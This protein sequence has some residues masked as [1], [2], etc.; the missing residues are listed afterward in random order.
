MINNHDSPKLDEI[1][2]GYV[3][4]NLDETELAWLNQELATNPQLRERIKQLEAT[5]TLIPY[6]LTDN[7]PHPL[8]KDKILSQ[9][10]LKQA[11]PVKFNRLLGITSV[12]TILSTLWLGLNNYGLR[13]QIAIQNNQLQ[14]HQELIA[15]LRQPNNRLVS[16][17]GLER[18]PQASGSLFIVPESK[19]A[20][21]ALQNLEPLPE[22]QVYRLWAVSP[23][24]T[25]GCAS[26]IPDERGTVHLQLSNNAL[27]DSSSLLITVEPQADTLQPEG[28]PI[29][30]STYSL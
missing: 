24:K 7:C 14:Q 13:R 11:K 30:T 22:K 1:L 21:L 27:N 25:T 4:G 3:L 2:A 29:L 18:L 9:A 8:L 28:S 10:R 17:K 23:D 15:L 16:F 12:I 5:L 26:F 19:T 6:G 20:I